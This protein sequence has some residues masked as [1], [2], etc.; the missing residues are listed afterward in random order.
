M[1]DESCHDQH[2]FS[3]KVFYSIKLFKEYN[4]EVKHSTKIRNSQENVLD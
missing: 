2:V 1:F 3:E 4:S